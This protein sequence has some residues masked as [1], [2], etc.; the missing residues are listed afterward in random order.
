MINWR[1]A[2]SVICSYIF[3]SLLVRVRIKR[4]ASSHVDRNLGVSFT[5]NSLVHG[6]YNYVTKHTYIISTVLFL[7][8]HMCV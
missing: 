7:G 3:C 2:V 1:Q 8:I 5:R 4:I 6:F